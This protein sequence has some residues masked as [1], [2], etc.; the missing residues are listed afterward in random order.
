[1]RMCRVIVLLKP[2]RER[3]GGALSV[4]DGRLLRRLRGRRRWDGGQPAQFRRIPPVDRRGDVGSGGAAVGTEMRRVEAHGAAEGGGE[5]RGCDCDWR[6]QDMA[7]LP[8]AA[9]LPHAAELTSS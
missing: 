7:I 1:S 2:R 8:S 4:T 3:S 6:S 9:C 5:D